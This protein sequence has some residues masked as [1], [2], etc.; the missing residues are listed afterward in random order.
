M[1]YHPFLIHRSRLGLPLVEVEALEIPLVKF[2]F[3]DRGAASDHATG[4]RAMPDMPFHLPNI[5]S[6]REHHVDI[7][8]A[9]GL[10]SFNEA[11]ND[12][13]YS[14]ALARL[15]LQGLTLSNALGSRI[16]KVPLESIR[17][18]RE[19]SRLSRLANNED[20]SLVEKK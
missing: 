16:R 17:L 2:L 6:I 9:S 1:H 7:L 18:A 20:N 12:I 3:S 8:M 14:I 5:L 13:H 19:R 15:A 10:D 4:G 11:L